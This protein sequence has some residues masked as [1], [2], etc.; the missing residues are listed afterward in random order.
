MN[1]QD[2][3]LPSLYATA[4]NAGGWIGVLDILCSE[5][6]VRNAAMQ[7]LERDG[8]RLRPVWTARDT[9]S[10]AHAELHDKHV[11]N[12]ENPRLDLRLGSWRPKN[13]IQ[14]SDRFEERSPDFARLRAGLAAIGLGRSICVTFELP[15]GQY[16]SLIMHKGVEDHRDFDRAQEGALHNLLPHLRQTMRLSAAM[17]EARFSASA[18]ERACDVVRTGLILCDTAG[19]VRWMNRSAETA[20]H[21]SPFLKLRAD[22]LYGVRAA[23]ASA[24]RKV[25]SAARGG[26]N[27]HSVAVLGD[28][29]AGALQLLCVP[30]GRPACEDPTGTLRDLRA[31]FL[32]SPGA[33]LP[34]PPE[35]LM[36]LF[37]LSPAEARLASAIAAGASVSSYSQSRGISVG[38]ARI[39]LK[40]IFAKTQAAKQ[41][42]LVRQLC[43]SVVAQTLSRLH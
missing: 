18:L 40:Q 3:L 10:L 6:S 11:N 38:T 22:R 33:P 24:L 41:A 20:I 31:I 26:G 29:D 35:D 28:Q 43:G 32:S 17:N 5:M 39:Q 14:D 7:I 16:F 4:D 30:I 9:Y 8:D 25:L 37:S 36:R 2:R 1:L 42:E 34:I 12:E 27:D 15:A 13:I 21:A 19:K 23:D